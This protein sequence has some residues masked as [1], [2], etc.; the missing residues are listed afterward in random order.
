MKGLI[1]INGAEHLEKKLRALADPDFGEPGQPAPV[2][3]KVIGDRHNISTSTVYR[4]RRKEGVLGHIYK[5]QLKPFTRRV[6]RLQ[7]S[8]V[9]IAKMRL[10]NAWN[11]K[12]RPTGMPIRG[13]L[14]VHW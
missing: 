12:P 14:D 1:G 10:M 8:K 9:A 7:F 13:R 3:S 11:S 6:R 5:R 2:K 4:M